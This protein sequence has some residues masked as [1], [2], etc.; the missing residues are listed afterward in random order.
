MATNS[1]MSDKDASWF[2]YI[3]SIVSGII[4]LAIS[5]TGNRMVKLHAWQSIFLG[6]AWLVVYAVFTLLGS[7]PILFGFMLLLRIFSGTAWLIITIFCIITAITG[8]IAKVPVLYD[9]AEK[10]A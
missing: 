4:V 8:S 3:L 7:I 9:M 1:G 6:L 2:A 10:M 5:K